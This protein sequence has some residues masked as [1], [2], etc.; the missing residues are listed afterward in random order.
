[1]TRTSGEYRPDRNGRADGSGSGNAATGHAD[2]RLFTSDFVFATLAN[3]ANAFGMQMLVATLP[4]YV[5]HMG[6]TQADAGLV[7]GALAFTALLFRP[8]VGWLT[9]A[10][11]RRP[12][13]LVGTSCYGFASVIYLLAG[14]I[15][16]L[17]L[18]HEKNKLM[19]EMLDKYMP[20][21]KGVRWTK[22][23]GGLFLWV[24]LPEKYDCDKIFAKAIDKK[25]AYV[26]G[27]AFYVGGRKKNSFR[28]NFSYPSMDQIREGVK[29]L[30]E[31][32]DNEIK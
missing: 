11:R 2:D 26:V 19:L 28:M 7:T 6:G 27:S 5:I 3:F 29:R 18:G 8:L 12:L 23:D 21:K 24:T 4:V 32:I 16:L 15:P 9:D 20:K 31:V 30:A 13:V 1:M 14:S 10:W 22:P 17:V 25:V